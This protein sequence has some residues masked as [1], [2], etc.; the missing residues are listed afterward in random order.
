LTW[1]PEWYLV[2]SSEHKLLTKYLLENTFK[3][4]P[5]ISRLLQI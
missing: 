4:K 1:S 2:R 5:A 3:C